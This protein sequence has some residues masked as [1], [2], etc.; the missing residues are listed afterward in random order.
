MASLRGARPEGHTPPAMTRAFP[1]LGISLALAGALLG[2]V[3]QAA[4]NPGGAGGPASGAGLRPGVGI[5]APGAGVTR[6]P[7]VDPVAYPANPGGAGGPA[8]GAG[9]RPG[10][11]A[12]AAGPG[13][14][15]VP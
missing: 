10:V 5:G 12:G 6:A 4:A 9:L 8:S 14:R 2:S 13:L 1:S 3:H 11:G 7:G 15:R